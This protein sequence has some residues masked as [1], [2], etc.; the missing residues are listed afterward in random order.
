M[1][2]KKIIAQTLK[3]LKFDPC[4]NQIANK[5][6]NLE[7]NIEHVKSFWSYDLYSRKPG[8]AYDKDGIFK[9]TDLDL[10]CFLYELVDRKAVINI[11]V[12]KGF[13]QKKFKSG[14]TLISKENRHGEIITLNSN[15]LKVIFIN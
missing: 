2:E 3:N 13:R 4:M 14:Q 1:T 9:G 15:M 7:D 11:P 5:S 8:P 12:Y 6:S 10:A